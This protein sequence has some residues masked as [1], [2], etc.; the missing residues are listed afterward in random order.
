MSMTRC[1]YLHG[2]ASG[3]TSSKGVAFAK[4]FARHG[5]LVERLDLRVPSLAHLRPSAIIERTLDAIGDRGP[6]PAR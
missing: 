3:P 1:L 4:N 6:V 5:A 2:F